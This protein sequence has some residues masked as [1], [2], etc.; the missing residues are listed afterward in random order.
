MDQ[1]LKVLS[2]V[3]TIAA[4]AVVVVILIIWYMVNKAR[5]RQFQKKMT[6]CQNKYNE[7]KNLTLQFKMN[8]A[9]NLSK[10]NSAR[11]HTDPRAD[12]RQS[13]EQGAKGKIFAFH[14]DHLTS[15]IV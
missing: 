4:I 1:F 8:K 9:N 6:E 11:R 5:S 12:R 3:R 2:D 15:A 7:I 13:R 14:G 10:I